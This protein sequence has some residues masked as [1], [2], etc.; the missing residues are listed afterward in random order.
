MSGDKNP[1]LTVTSLISKF[2][3]G[4][5]DVKERS[6]LFWFVTEPF[7]TALDAIEI[8]GEE[9]SILNVNS[10]VLMFELLAESSHTNLEKVE[11]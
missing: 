3:T 11:Y 2:S 10:E 9:L 6:I 8:D 1:P 5:F 7:K 4:T